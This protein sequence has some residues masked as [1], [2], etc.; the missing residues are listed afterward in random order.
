MSG[1]NEKYL[2]E[3]FLGLL[4]QIKVF[5]WATMSYSCHKA[6]DDLHDSLSDQVD[7]LMEV[8]IGKYER[9]PLNEFKI[10]MNATSNTS[11]IIEY[12][13]ENREAIRGTLRNKHFK[14]C[15]EI[16]NILDTMLATI[17]RS[18]YLLNLK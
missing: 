6:L 17:S 3:Y 18:I 15:T 10:S 8:Y 2:F 13:K 1:I 5:H 16:Q 12:L 9:Q 7:E 11:N 4:G 14:S